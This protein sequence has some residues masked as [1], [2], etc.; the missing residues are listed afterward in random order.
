MG[1]LLASIKTAVKRNAPWLIPIY[2][3]FCWNFVI[4]P[5]MRRAGMN[6]F[7]D[8]YYGNAWNGVESVSGAGSTLA[9][10][11]VIRDTLPDVIRDLGI[12]SILDIPCGDFHWMRDTY[13]P[14]DL[15]I[16]ADIVEELIVF[17][18]EV[19]STAARKFIVCDLT[20]DTLPNVDMIFCRDC[21]FHFSFYDIFRTIVNVRRSKAQFFFTTTNPNLERNIDVVTGEW[22]PLN[23]QIPPFSFPKP[24]LLVDEDPTDK[25]D[26]ADKHMALWR[27]G[28]L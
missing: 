18:T 28:D 6:I 3:Y 26:I 7:R 14:L 10:T 15:Y 1:N 27:V 12:R 4:R 8:L 11:I 17:N 5:R 22:R 16:G 19:Y 13:L 24:L 25:K 9:A 21:L 2:S 23:L 20:T